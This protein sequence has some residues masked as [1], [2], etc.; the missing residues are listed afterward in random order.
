M[1]CDGVVPAWTE[2]YYAIGVGRVELGE[3]FHEDFDGWEG[4][5]QGNFDD[6][7]LLFGFLA[8]LEISHCR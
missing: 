7:R 8:P 5:L 6:W 3:L 1:E 2:V 4:E